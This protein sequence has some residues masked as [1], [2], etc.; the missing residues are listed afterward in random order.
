MA[1]IQIEFAGQKTFGGYLKIDGGRQIKCIDGLIIP[2]SAGTH[3]ISLSSDSSAIKGLNK[4]NGWLGNDDRRRNVY[5]GNIT[6]AF[7]ENSLMTLTIVSDGWGHIIGTP[8]TSTFEMDDEL[9]EKAD[10]M[11]Q[12]QQQAVE[13]EVEKANDGIAVELLLCLFLGTLGAH[14][15][16]RKKIGMG[17]LYL[18]TLGLFGIGVIVDFVKIIIT[19]SKKK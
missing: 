9:K 11:Y 8:Q 18:F 19:M 17:I 14:K 1:Y 4:V 6:A 2:V 3:Y 15:F 7:E 13:Q 12:E 10:K 16:Y 5:D